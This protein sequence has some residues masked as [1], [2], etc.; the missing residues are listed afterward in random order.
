VAKVFPPVRTECRVAKKLTVELRSSENAAH[1][2]TS[3]MNVS[4]HGARV[5]TKHSWT[6]DQDV[7]V[8]AVPGDLSLRAHVIYCRPLPD[9]SFFIGLRLLQSSENWP[10]RSE[11]TPRR[12]PH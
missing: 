4:P 2:I 1:E 8:R 3:T 10:A 12:L 6:P 7:C 11:S 5:L 9:S